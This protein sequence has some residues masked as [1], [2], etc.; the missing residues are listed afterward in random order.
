M[1]LYHGT[2]ADV[3]RRALHEGLAPRCETGVESHWEAVSREDLVYMTT[4][5]A[6]YFGVCAAEDG[7]HFAVVE[8]DTNKLDDADMRP[9]EDF[10]EQALRNHE[11]MW[12]EGE[13]TL[14]D[15]TTYAREVLVDHFADKWSDSLDHLGTVAHVGRIPPEAITRVAI[16]D[17]EKMSRGVVMAITDP[18][19][20]LLNHRFMGEKY[21]G[22][23]RWLFGGDMEP[24]TFIFGVTAEGNDF[25][26]MEDFHGR[27]M[28]EG[29]RAVLADRGGIE[30]VE[31]EVVRAAE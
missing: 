25:A 16:C 27:A 21:R 10:V 9:D 18:Q 7:Q 28:F 15:R 2:T 3:G 23:T 24:A 11:G 17:A 14:E 19:I 31:A 30:V 8:I 1:F 6:P 5:Y 29:A 22:L 20:S 4:T 26:A 12:G 13:T